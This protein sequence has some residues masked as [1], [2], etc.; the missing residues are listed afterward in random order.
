MSCYS[1]YIT[2]SR[3][4][5]SRSGLYAED[6]P[7]VDASMWEGLTKLTSVEEFWSMI[8]KKAWDG[9]VSD[10]THQLQNKF[11][12][13]SKLV[14]RE[15]SQL[16]ADFNATTGLAGVTIEF[17]LPRYAKLHVISV[18][19]YSQEEYNSPEAMIQVYEDDADG[20]LL[21]EHS[22]EITEGRNTIFIDQDYEVNKIFVAYDPEIYSFRKT[23]NKRYN[24]PYISWSCDECAFDCGGYQGKILQ[25]NGGGLNVKYNVFCSVEKFL[26]ENINLF[27]QAFFFRIGLEIIFERKYGN[28]LNKWTTMTK[29]SQ[30]KFIQFYSKNFM[31][32]LERSVR[33]QSINEDPYC[34]TC[35]HTVSKQSSIP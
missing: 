16:K 21:S 34:F 17:T 11:Y 18:D 30:E 6:L 13:D 20:E 26:C 25:V 7:G 1:D 10:L 35:K 4:N 19:V 14:S 23:E 15:T 2:R 3:I 9:L 32:N 24:T 28:R 12:V 22:Q 31:D 8:Y 29:E 27:K 5:P 33:S